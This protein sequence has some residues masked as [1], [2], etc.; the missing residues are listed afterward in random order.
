MD[1]PRNRFKHAIHEGKAQIGLWVALADA[2]CAE[3]SAGAGFD[4]LLL[5][6]EHGPNHLRTL[7]GQLQAVAPYESHPVVRLP[8]GETN[9]IKQ[10]LEIGAQTL[11]IPMV[12]TAEQAAALVAAMH[13]PPAGIRG[14]GAALGRSSRW[15]RMPII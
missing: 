13:Y 5:D 8:Y 15:N 14:V 11:L 4:W 12:E 2:G 10:V 6:A 1:V 7:L 3:L 9:L